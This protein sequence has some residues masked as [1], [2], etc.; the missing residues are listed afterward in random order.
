M[1]ML[2]PVAVMML[3]FLLLV[4]LYALLGKGHEESK[5]S[6]RTPVFQPLL[7][8]PAEGNNDGRHS[9]S[10]GVFPEGY[11]IGDL[12]NLQT[13]F[14]EGVALL[15]ADKGSAEERKKPLLP[16]EVNPGVIQEVASRISALKNIDDLHEIQRIIDDPKAA[17]EAFSQIIT[18]NPLLSAKIL[19][20]ANSPF[21]GMEKKMNSISHAIM[22]IG[23]VNLRG[24]I[25]REGIMNALNRG[26]HHDV[27]VMQELWQH[28]Q[29]TSLCASHLYYLF[30]GLNRG[31]LFT[32]ALLHDI[33]K[34]ILM[35]LPRLTGES[36]PTRPYGPDWTL[37]EE[38]ECYGINHTLVGRLALQHW[39]LS[40]TMIGAIAHH[41]DPACSGMGDL[42]L[43]HE[44]RKYLLV[45]FLA[46]HAAHLYHGAT[47]DNPERAVARD[48]LHP[49]YHALIDQKKLQHLL[50]DRSL[51]GQLQETEALTRVYG[52]A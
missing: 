49:S 31:V 33:G 8:V 20:V 22:I 40:E 13:C 16:E 14:R 2:V 35:E 44:A 46:N 9:E 4:L 28:A 25:Y 21:Y 39:G 41:H 3:I 26:D 37:A 52:T 38:D 51:L 7:R 1:E 45:L 6:L 27:V 43:S 42:P 17:V 19:R 10:E 32:T 29:Y 50:L 24:I 34:M 47:G 36:V 23:L 18:R 12:K 15:F 30:N 48:H 11:Q 5:K